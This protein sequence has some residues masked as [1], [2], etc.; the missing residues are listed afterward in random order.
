MVMQSHH[1]ETDEARIGT[2]YAYNQAGWLLEKREP[3]SRAEDGS[4]QYRLTQ[5]VYDTNGN[6]TEE[7][8]FLSFQDGE[9]ARGSIHTL[10]FGYDKQN[11]LVRV[12][13]GLGAVV[14]YEYDGLNRRIRET[15]LL[16]EGLTQRVD[17]HYDPAG[18]LIEV[19]QSADQEGCGSQ[20]ASTRYEYDR[21]G[22]ITRIQLPA[23]G[24]IL[25]EYDAANR[26][27][28]ET[29]REERSGINNRTQFGYDAAGNLVEITDNQGR[30]TRIAYDLL[31]RE[32]R[33][34]ERDGGV[35]RTIYDR[36]GQ[37]V[38]LIRP[39]EYDAQTDSGDGFQFTY[40][41][42]G[43]VLTVLSPDGHVLQ[44]NA[45]DA[46]GRLLQ[47]LDGVGSGV[48]Y[49]Y[50]LAGAQRRIVSMGGAS[51]E[52]EYDARGRIT[53]IVDGNG[54]ETKYLLDEWGRITG[55]VKADGSTERYAYNF[56][57]D[58]VS[59][60]DGEGHTTQYEYN[61]MGK[62]SAIVDP[63]GERETY[64]YDGQGRLIRK[65]DRNGVTVELGYNLYGTP[66]FKKEKDGAQGDFYE[67]TPE[68]LLKCAISAGMRYAYE[69][70]EMGRMTRKSASGRTLLALEYDKNGNKVRQ[71][72]V[73]GK[74][75][76]FDYDPMGQLLRLVDDGQ[77]LA[78]YT[79]NPDGTP[80]TVTHGPIRQ[81]Y[82]YD[83]DKNL[84]GLTVRSG[85]TLLSQ[86][87]Y[88]Y[89]GNG[90]RI[91]KQALDGTTLYQYDALNQ[92]QRVDYPA[93]SEELF[94]DKAGNR[95]RRLVGGE[96]ELYQYDPRNRLMALTRGGVTTPFQY[97][98]AGNLLQD[99]KA[100]YSYD[101]FNRTVKVETFDG[102][103]QI[104]RYDAEGLR[105]EM[106]ENS[107]LVRFIFHK[108]EAVAEQEEN[109]NVIRLI[110]GSEL[111]ARSSDSES[112]RTYYHYASDEMGSTTHIVDENGNVQNRY[113]YDAWGKIEVKEEA[114]PNRFTY[115]GQQ[116]DP[117]TQQYYLRARFYNPVIG[118][119]TQEDTY[120]GD[121]L[122][123]YAYCANNPVYYIDPSGYSYSEEEL[124]RFAEWFNSASKEDIK[125]LMSI[126]DVSAEIKTALRNQ[127]SMHEWLPVSQA[128]ISRG[129]GATAEDIW[130]WT[131]PTDSTYFVNIVDKKGVLHSGLH[132]KDGSTAAHNQ[133]F[134]MMRESPNIEEFKR[135]LNLW[136]DEHVKLIDPNT[137]AD[138]LV[139]RNALPDG[140]R[141]SESELDISPRAIYR[142][143]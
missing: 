34:I 126:K 47:R 2:L 54:S 48:K 90:N 22:N 110:R 65:T 111:I 53:G 31:N 85:D 129:W 1:G 10:T 108:G 18:R 5:Y 64:H 82:A 89:D 12:S 133:I 46:D 69:Y 58:M 136:A 29:H 8:R 51:Q 128:T 40:D 39:N 138:I 44:S 24:E 139:G 123:L 98:N 130:T 55:V 17:Y 119:F 121:G 91:R 45:Y 36:N 3:V 112:A 107:R 78:A 97:D 143:K 140:L 104:N 118:R 109:S 56:A 137:G 61:R 9:S 132:G 83:L 19:E 74:L 80:R 115:Y 27:I 33:R 134:A 75:T 102:N 28:A 86:T 37:V 52:L 114:V 142:N 57:G 131:T 16:S 60:T 71:I 106:E 77:E 103:V 117:I 141:I 94:Y 96:E 20:F 81:E 63:T 93:Y 50:D 120:R 87:S 84:M 26:L 13:D 6:R 72:D 23:G 4:V 49:E 7:K 95:A 32:I 67:Y 122:N 124:T 66:L 30:K 92:L 116:I 101:A 41:A 25:R 125:L 43:R 35:Q 38:R 42:Q 70:D 88:A 105:H 14:R 15:R 79:Y 76:G 21:N 68:G 62:I 11:R 135:K 59:S 127:G 100:R 99:D 113:A 73:T